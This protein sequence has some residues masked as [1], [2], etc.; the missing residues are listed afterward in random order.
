MFL[1]GGVDSSII[2]AKLK[3]QNKNK[4]K[5]FTIG[6]N[7][8]EFDE[9]KYAKKIANYLGTDHHEF[10]I[11]PDDIFK[12][13][14]DL[15]DI[16]S[17]PFA[18]SSQIP[19]ALICREIKDS[20]ITVALS[21]DGGDEIFGGYLRH[22]M[23]NNLWNKINLL[24]FSLRKQIG[25][26]LT[27]LPNQLW[28]DINIFNRQNLGHKIS[29]FNQSLK[30]SQTKESLYKSLV[31]DNS[32]EELYSDEFKKLLVLNSSK[33]KFSIFPPIEKSNK[34]DFV[35]KMLLWDASL[36]LTDDILVKVDR[37]SMHY[38]L[39][40]RAPFLDARLVEVASKIPYS[41][42][43][44]KNYGKHILRKLLYKYIPTH[45]RTKIGFALVG[46]WLRALKDW[47][48][49]FIYEKILI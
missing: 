40:T 49:N 46:E 45:F 39:E 15:P 7:N 16:Y 14:N 20:G 35:D 17:E 42:K 38:S 31:I 28:N 3:S 34:I 29:K 5:T 13:I 10:I 30:N 27:S 44:K 25:T 21:G 36:Y 32:F 24:P 23:I 2:T 1:S 9:S 26:Y 12:I 47:A 18:D 22:Y 37:A 33:N 19:T 6:F 48:E 41:L 8:K 11:N 4:I 43:I